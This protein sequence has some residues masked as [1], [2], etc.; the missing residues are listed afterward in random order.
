MPKFF[1]YKE[2]QKTIRDG[3]E[4]ISLVVNGVSCIS[5]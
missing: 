1:W 5:N 2:L 3:R 4:A